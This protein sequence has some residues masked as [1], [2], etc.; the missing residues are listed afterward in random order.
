MEILAGTGAGDKQRTKEDSKLLDRIREQCHS[1]V[2][3]ELS[4]LLF[5][6]LLLLPSRAL[7]DNS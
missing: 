4:T 2:L 6:L 7:E 3:I 5:L 1:A